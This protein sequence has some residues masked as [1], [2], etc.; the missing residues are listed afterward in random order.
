IGDIL[1][2]IGHDNDLNRFEKNIATR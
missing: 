1:I 2:M